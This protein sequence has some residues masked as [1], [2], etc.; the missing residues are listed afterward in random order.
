[1][2]AYRETR[3][4]CKPPSKILP[5]VLEQMIN[6]LRHRLA[7]YFPSKMELIDCRCTVKMYSVPHYKT[8]FLIFEHL[9][10]VDY[11]QNHA[12]YK[13]TQYIKMITVLY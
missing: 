12:C 7:F 13:H 6:R 8:G 4:P 11:L 5:T 2:H 3:H 10:L 9:V 1:M